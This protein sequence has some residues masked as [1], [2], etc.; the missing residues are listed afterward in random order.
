MTAQEF[1]G[2]AIELLNFCAFYY[3][4]LLIRCALISFVVFALVIALRKT[5]LKNMVFLKGAAWALFIP[6]LFAGK[7]KFFDESK[8]GMIFSNCWRFIGVNYIWI[9]WLYFCVVVLYAVLIFRRKRKLKCLVASMERRKVEGISVYVTNIPVTPSTIGAFRP[10]IVVP[11]VMLKEYDREELQAIL[12]HEKVHIRLGHLYFYLLWDILRVLLW[13][14]PLLTVGTKYFRED[15]EEICDRVTIQKA[16]AEAYSYGQLLLKSMRTLQAE[17]DAFNLYATFAGDTGYQNIRQRITKVAGYKPYKQIAAVG[18]I[19]TAVLCMAGAIA[20]MQN[21]SYARNIENENMLIYGYD[22]NEVSFIDHSDALHQMISYDDSYV[23]VDSEAFENHLCQNNVSG[24]IFIV[25]GGFQKLP[26]IG[27]L[28]YM[29]Q[30]ENDV[31]T[32]I[33]QIPYEDY[34]RDWLINFYRSL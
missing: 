11:E 29:C 8:M 23:Y 18:T 16:K 2:K 5:I 15:M 27:G 25:F 9:C 30:Y 22:S 7:M 34:K 26:G 17:A 10:K 28:S 19:V 1:V 4:V 33:V 6:V 21:I 32:K 14:N 13:L 31:N 12:L 24:E 3:V 20:W